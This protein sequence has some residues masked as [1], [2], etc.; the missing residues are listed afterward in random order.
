[1]SCGQ[2]LGP[3]IYVRYGLDAAG[4]L[5]C[6]LS[7]QAFS[8]ALLSGKF[9]TILKWTSSLHTELHTSH[10]DLTFSSVLIPCNWKD[11]KEKA[12]E[13]LH[14]ILL[15]VADPC[16]SCT[17]IMLVPSWKQGL[18][19]DAGGNIVSKGNQMKIFQH[20]H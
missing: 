14:L 18:L 4:G 1:V 12:I 2:R 17:Y 13:P 6:L 16:Q 11:K 10:S 5:M 15:A 7:L 8:Q 19:G 9:P 20:H 3:P